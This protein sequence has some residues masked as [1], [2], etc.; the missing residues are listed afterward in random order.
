MTG[1]AYYLMR[2]RRGGPLVPARL[3][4]ID[5]EPGEPDNKRD[6]WPPEI[7]FVDIAGEVRTPE[8]LLERFGVIQGHWRTLEPITE[9][10][11]RFRLRHMRWAETHQPEHPT[12]RPRRKADPRT[13]PL[14]KFTEAP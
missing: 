4:Y 13:Y 5:H 7:P 6:R 10:E 2:V 8:E 3:Q 14:P 9:A 1:P 11:Y 12:V